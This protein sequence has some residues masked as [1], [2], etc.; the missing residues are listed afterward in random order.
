MDA[1]FFGTAPS[2]SALET[3]RQRVLPSTWI[4]L[5]HRLFLL[6]KYV[7]PT[8]F[9]FGLRGMFTLT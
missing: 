7:W 2:T 8:G 6:L 3:N 9:F 1:F 4:F 5:Y